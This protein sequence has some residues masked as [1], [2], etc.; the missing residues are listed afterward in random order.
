MA[1]TASLPLSQRVAVDGL[2][3]APGT[4]APLTSTFHASRSAS[5]ML[6]LPPRAAF[7]GEASAKGAAEERERSA[8][9][10]G[11]V[12]GAGTGEAVGLSRRVLLIGSGVV[13]AVGPWFA[14]GDVARAADVAPQRYFKTPSGATV[15]GMLSYIPHIPH[16]PSHP[17]PALTSRTCPHIP[18]LPSHPPPASYLPFLHALTPTLTHP[19]TPAH[20][21]TKARS[22]SH[23]SSHSSPTH[24]EVY[25]GQGEA[26]TAGDAVTV[27]YVCRRSNGYFLASTI[28][29]VGGDADPIDLLLGQGQ[30]IQGLEEAVQGMRAGGK[31]RV[32]V[33]PSLGYVRPD[34]QPQPKDRAL[35]AHVKEPLIFEVQLIKVKPGAAATAV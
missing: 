25:E 15:E 30:V 5:G 7:R 12:A 10:A 35:A 8:A 9:A 17:A 2:C 33:P 6:A 24:S 14:A 23:L 3:R 19:H 34:M 28:D 29:P 27:H 26:A 32:L 20:T 1:F 11:A 21:C 22:S 16:L 4:A 31:R 18:H 13:T